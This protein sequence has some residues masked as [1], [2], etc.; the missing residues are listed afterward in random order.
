VTERILIVDDEQPILD[1]LRL[2]LEREG[3]DDVAEATTVAAAESS[4]VGRAPALIVL[5]V[6]LPDGDGFSLAGSLR[7][8]T[9]APILFLTARGADM[10]KLIGFGVGGDDYVTKPFNPLEV[11]ARIKALL[12][13][14][15]SVSATAEPLAVHDW[16]RFTLFEDEGRL[17]VEGRDI[18]MPAR[19]QQLLAF[20][21]RNPGRVFSKRQLYRQ[22]WGEE[23]LGASDDN[24][25][26]VHVHRIR[27]R[28]EPDPST[29]R[30]LLT[31]RGLGYKLAPSCGGH[32]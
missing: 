11:V 23:A 6:M 20:L 21:C 31:V 29:P 8:V 14:S 30:L 13:R 1:L 5:D 24:T 26:Q 28:V 18:P 22:V 17:T 7:S 27:E 4:A 32:R 12:R 2:V 3:F 16:G 9:Q 25:V 10:D 19:E 15:G